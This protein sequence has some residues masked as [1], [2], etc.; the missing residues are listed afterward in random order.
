MTATARQPQSTPIP[1]PTNPL[2]ELY[3]GDSVLSPAER[4]AV[5]RSELASLVDST[6][7]IF[8]KLQ[9][10]VVP[11]LSNAI[12]E[13]CI[14]VARGLSDALNLSSRVL[15]DSISAVEA[16][17]A[18]SSIKAA[19][20]DVYD[21]HL[22]AVKQELTIP[23]PA[24]RGSSPA[25]P[26]IERCERLHSELVR[27]FEGPVTQAVQILERKAAESQRLDEL[28][29]TGQEILGKA[30]IDLASAAY[31]I[32]DIAP[33]NRTGGSISD[34]L[35]AERDR[36]TDEIAALRSSV[37][38]KQAGKATIQELETQRAMCEPLGPLTQKL[39]EVCSRCVTK[40]DTSV[41][42][43]IDELEAASKSLHDGTAIE[44]VSTT[45]LT[46]KARATLAS[47]LDNTVAALKSFNRSVNGE[48]NPELA[49][50]SPFQLG[51]IFVRDAGL[52]SMRVFLIAEQDSVAM[53]IAAANPMNDGGRKLHSLLTV[54]VGNLA[55]FEGTPS[56][57]ELNRSGAVLPKSISMNVGSVLDCVVAN[58]HGAFERFG[59]FDPASALFAG[60]KA[61]Q[62]T[63]SVSHLALQEISARALGSG[64]FSKLPSPVARLG[65]EIDRTELGISPLRAFLVAERDGIY[66]K[67]VTPPQ[68]QGFLSWA[69]EH[70]V[71]SVRVG[72][73]PADQ[74]AEALN[75]SNTQIAN[76]SLAVVGRVL[77]FMT[78]PPPG[79]FQP[80]GKFNAVGPL[81]SAL[82]ALPGVQSVSLH[83]VPARLV[84]VGRFV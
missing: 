57:A 13:S 61:L 23:D 50:R 72:T 28:H 24:L 52:H 40:T 51:E 70:S 11:G 42:V 66:L 68:R 27:L 39:Q 18:A 76:G 33:Q 82:E 46:A 12:G 80:N 45:S 43:K 5:L 63:G 26:L 84:K 77:D 74:S 36:I 15:G 2:S 56:A 55:D 75:A 37:A 38:G 79:S 29:R 19:L 31:D 65:K 60:L 78:K 14:N 3:A 62:T 4:V 10:R 32:V 47:V 1:T 25:V 9:D 34:I 69:S 22:E 59:R 16:K 58:Q 8:R 30:S 17:D 20:N 67:V 48:P 83:D 81:V 35:L 6:I 73:L 41:E 7:P 21:L 71:L 54:K 64:D 53:K 49:L 44:G